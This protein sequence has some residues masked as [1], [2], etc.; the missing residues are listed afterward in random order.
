MA[1]WAA[2]LSEKPKHSREI[3]PRRGAFLTGGT[4]ETGVDSMKLDPSAITKAREWFAKR[5]SMLAIGGACLFLLAVLV[6]NLHARAGHAG[7]A[8]TKAIA[9]ATA[10]AVTAKVPT[11]DQTSATNPHIAQQPA[12]A[13]PAAATAAPAAPVPVAAPIQPPPGIQRGFFL[14]KNFQQAQ[15]ALAQTSAGVVDAQ[16]LSVQAPATDGDGERATEWSAWFNLTSP[17]TIAWVRLAGG[18]GTVA[19]TIDGTGLGEAAGHW[20]PQGAF[21]NLATIPLAAG[22]HQ[23][24]I[25]DTRRSWVRGPG[26]AVRIDLGDGTG[27]TVSPQPWA[28]PPGAPASA[29]IPRNACAHDPCAPSIAQQASASASSSAAKPASA[30]TAGST[31]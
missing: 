25:H 14:Q 12:P 22:W 23:I 18:Q 31:P 30:S 6:V 13:T 16:T 28:V 10:P 17:T 29:P 24:T 26:V 11:V 27:A 4:H 1:V 3:S 21:S 20:Q 8:P 9:T 7:N 2:R 5:W 15:F 19:V